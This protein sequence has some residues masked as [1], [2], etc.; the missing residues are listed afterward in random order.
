MKFTLIY[1]NQLFYNHPALSK[2]QQIVIVEDPLFFGDIQ[3]P[4][5][6]H[7]KK[8]VLH[9]ASIESFREELID[10]G[11]SAIIYKY[12]DLIEKNHNIKLLK[13]LKATEISLA[14]VV[15]Y[16]L[17]KRLVSAAKDLNIKINWFETPGFF[18]DAEEVVEIFSNKKKHLM[19]SFYINQ[20]KKL[21]ILLD[22][23]YNPIGG[24]WSFDLENRKKLPK[25][26]VIPPISK[27]LYKKNQIE[28][29][30][31]TVEQEFSSNL[32][33]IKN[34]NFPISR[35][36][37]QKSFREF[38]ENRLH[39]FGL[40]EDAIAKE[41]NFIF[42]SIITPYLNIG[43]IT[44]DEIISE[45]IEYA[46]QNEIPLNSLEGFVRQIIGWREFIRGIYTT[47]GVR[48][49]NGNFWK[50]NREIPNAF[51]TGNTGLDPLDNS[52]K[53]CLESGYT[54]HIERLM[55][56]GN[57]M[58]LL[59]IKPKSVYNWFMEI[60]IDSYDWVMVPNIFGMSQYADGGLMSTKPYISGSN[61]ILKMSNYK[62][63]KWSEVWDALYWNFIN[64]NREFF[65]KN[66]RMSM[67]V[68]MYDRQ[69][70]EKKNRDSKIVTTFMNSLFLT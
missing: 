2:H 40:Y 38:L 35:S 36:Q 12:S 31:N 62:K 56:L 10:R 22:D 19:N 63:G 3:Y 26:I 28:K 18:L 1:P 11:Y 58:V 14:R 54:H 41:N 61:Y 45:T 27:I 6:F 4:L 69:N 67:M 65:K 57:I 5:T 48:Q 30:I 8:I 53:H 44:P 43:L 29:S 66:P 70:L 50:F 37:A 17:E 52:I 23:N 32:G 68:S 59:G 9:L 15:D 60:F 20:R 25:N 64:K 46:N 16:T 42:H 33:T 7:K 51:Y 34:F 49:R 13:S 55:I 21:N 39:L 47:D 24:K